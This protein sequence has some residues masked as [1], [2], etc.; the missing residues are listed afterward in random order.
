MARN[1]QYGSRA[2]ARSN[3]RNHWGLAVAALGI[4]SALPRCACDDESGIARAQVELHMSFL[5]RD[6]C[7]GL[8]VGRRIPDDYTRTGQAASTDFGSR[9]ERRFE[10]RS[11]GRAPLN[12]REIVLSEESAEF[13]LTITDAEGEPLTLPVQLPAEPDVTRPPGV[14][15]QIAYASADNSPDLVNLIVRSD[16]EDRKE[17][18]FGLSAGR[19]RLEVCTGERC[20]SDAAI[21]FGNVPLGGAGMETITLENVGEGDLDLRSIR[22]ESDSAEFCA[23]EATEIPDGTPNC[24]PVSL[25]LVLRPGESYTIN[26]SYHPND[27]GEDT[28]KVVI[29][30]GDAVSGNVEV[31]INGTGAG[32]AVCTCVVEGA[33]CNTTGLVDFGLADVGA[34]VA[35]TLRLVSCGTD[36]VEI[37]EAMLETDASNPFFTGPEFQITGGFAT[38]SLPPGMFTEGEITYSPQA[39]GIHRGGLR[40]AVSQTGLRSWVGLVGQASTC[41]L[42]VLPQM[43]NFNTVAGG[44]TADRTVTL[45][46]NGAKDCVVSVVTDP[47]APFA[48]VN[49]PALPLSV[50]P[51]ASEPLTVRFSPAAGPVQSYMDSFQVTSDEPGPG[52]TSTVNLVGQGGGT[53]ECALNIVPSGNDIGIRVRDGRLQFGAVN[54]GYSKILP[55][56]IE[57]TGNAECVLQSFNLTTE[58]ASEFQVAPSMPLP[59]AIPPG[60]SAALNVTFAP[61]RSAS[62][63]L[64]LYGGFLNYVAF[65][66]QGPAL[67]KTDWEISLSAQPTEP[68]IDVLPPNVDFGVVTWERPQAPDMR[69]SCGSQ[70]RTVNVYNSGNGALQI[71]GIT[72]DQTSDPVFLV[73]QVR[74]AGSVINPPYTNIMISAGANIEVDLRFFPSR[75]NP[76]IH[77]GLLVID[78]SVTNPQGSGSPLTVPLAGEG[79]TN[80]S[81][82]DIF[83]QLSDNKI[84]ILWVVDDSGSMSE[85]Q[86]LLAQNF[87]SFINFADSLSVD[88]QVAVTTTE[89]ND[90]VSG[91]IWA[92]S[93][94]PKILTPSVA[95]RVQAFQ[96]A[97]N[98][99]NPPG[100]NSR[101]NPGGSDEQEAGLQAARIALDVPVVTG[102]NA[103]FMR[104]DARLAVIMVSDEEDQSDGSV[105]LYIDFF[106]NLKG[107][108]NPQL[109]SVSAIAGDVP[110]G[111]ATADAGTRYQ[112]AVQAIG[113]QFGSVC[114]NSWQTLL[115]NIGLGV[116]ALRSTWTLSRQADPASI[117]VR[118]N[119]NSVAQSGTN[120]WSYDPAANTVTFNGNAIPPPG[121]RIEVQ[122]GAVCLP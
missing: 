28:G 110:G 19:G 120:G 9:G 74:Q 111:C 121:A 52:A 107:F 47:S 39:G 71:T 82:T 92:C 35:K 113:G 37:T 6:T 7:S 58:A 34:S 122:Y 114:S 17:V 60:T 24:A 51:G 26:V 68:T 76:G 102:A 15:I 108:R 73:N 109:V 38:G 22:L 117:T 65:N 30:S 119:G 14:V 62:N 69:S 50:A 100:G 90:G 23:P 54:I 20:G 64:G 83:N 105:N 49:K 4:A 116:F 77:Q 11:V 10:L 93:G 44:T 21:A 84:D 61:T 41:D 103:G 98:V 106:R 27:G 57:N 99:T 85:E 3:A 75:A 81:Q 80:T 8:D 66:V 118:V 55:I 29:V 1:C 12:I 91:E 63:L 31:P 2:L 42:E 86:N 59:Y 79:T 46:N 25:C 96:C 53:P 70:T 45:V 95:N 101:P 89:V 43:V 112:N 115:Q 13:T 97:A 33:D 88:Y 18:S 72:I 78:N 36:A 5:E 40:Y 48:I 104:P 32:P 16:D 87:A 67:T 94:F 56:R